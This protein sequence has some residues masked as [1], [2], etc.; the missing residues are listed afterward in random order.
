MANKDGY[1]KYCYHDEGDTFEEI[2]EGGEKALWE[3][4]ADFIGSRYTMG[5]YIDRGMMCLSTIIGDVSGDSVW[6]E[7]INFCPMCGRKI[8]RHE[9]I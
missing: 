6:G 9:N 5:M 7:A 8:D 1:C 4:Q 3:Y 2:Y